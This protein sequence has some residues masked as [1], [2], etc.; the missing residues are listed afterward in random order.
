MNPFQKFVSEQAQLVDLLQCMQRDPFRPM[1][2][3]LAVVISAW[4]VVTDETMTPERWL[5]TEMP[6]L[7]QFLKSNTESFE[8]EVFGVSAQGGVITEDTRR[9]LLNKVPSR[10][11][12]CVVGRLASSDITLPLKWLSEVVNG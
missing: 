9:D 11:I 7:T 4:D 1:K 10:R 2:R 3:R 6:L 8:T 12:R 5:A